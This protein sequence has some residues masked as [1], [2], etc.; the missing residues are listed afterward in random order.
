ML[1]VKKED[2]PVLVEDVADSNAT[3]DIVDVSNRED[4]FAAAKVN[5]TPKYT[6]WYKKASY[7]KIVMEK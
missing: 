7:Y 2:M 4:G 3:V 5:I 6:M 1:V